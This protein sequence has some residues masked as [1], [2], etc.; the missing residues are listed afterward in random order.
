LRCGP[1]LCGAALSDAQR[2]LL[3][4]NGQQATGNRQKATGNR[5]KVE[6]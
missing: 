4:R 5:A 1:C 2:P 3:M 6:Y